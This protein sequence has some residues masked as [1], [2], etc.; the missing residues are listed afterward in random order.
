MEYSH[1]LGLGFF[2]HVFII[3]NANQ[4]HYHYPL[5]HGMEYSHYLGLGT[6]GFQEYSVPWVVTGDNGPFVIPWCKSP[7]TNMTSLG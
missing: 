1:Y 7:G 5:H 6:K 3:V 2:L 4:P